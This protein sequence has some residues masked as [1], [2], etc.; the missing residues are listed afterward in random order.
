MSKRWT[1]VCCL[2]ALLFAMVPSRASAQAV[3]GNIIGT[4]TDQ[5]GA[6][7]PNAK[8]TVTDVRKGTSDTFTTNSDGN[9]SATHLIP[10][11]YRV[12]IEA[13]GFKTAE[14][15]PLTVNADASAR[16]D[17]KL[18]LGQVSEQVEV[19]S[20]APQLKTD[21]SDVNVTFND[22][23]VQNLPLVN[24]NFQSILLDSPGT[25]E[26]AGWNHASTEN[27]QA[28]H[29]IFVN[30]QNFSG[31]GYELDGTD[32]QDPILGI[33]VINPNVDAVTEAKVSEQNYFDAEFGKA[34]AGLVTVQTKSGSN[35]LHGSGFWYRRSDANAARDPFTQF[36]PDPITGRFL[37]RARWQNFGATA[38]G[39]I[40]K[41]KL[42]IFGD[43]QGTR[44]T[45]GITNLA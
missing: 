5:S 45:S 25:Q 38:G 35:E 11:D 44:Q 15:Q 42:F 22:R 43:Y 27:P 9:Y 23:Y 14:S 19:T 32:N 41:D 26:L 21:R 28:S 34:T 18:Q 31:T 2:F 33:I 10:D 36:A 16:F 13:P 12:R 29:Q 39:P 24:R 37:P 17:A 1:G 8:V 7:V 3:Y 30:G 40:I 20:E 6:A 4:V